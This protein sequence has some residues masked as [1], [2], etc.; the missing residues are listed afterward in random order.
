MPM[1]N[2]C[3]KKNCKSSGDVSPALTQVP[4]V[5]QYCKM[6]KCTKLKILKHLFRDL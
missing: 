6:P 3:A 2:K 1:K 5:L 4:Q